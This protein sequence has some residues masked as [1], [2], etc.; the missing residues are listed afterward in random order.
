MRAHVVKGGKVVN[1]IEV[2][3]LDFMPGLI[4][5]TCGSIGWCCLDGALSP[6]AKELPD[7]KAKKIQLVEEIRYLKIYQ[8]SIPYTFP[9]D[10]DPDGIQMRDEVD[11]QNIQDL[12]I[13]AMLLDPTDTV[14]FMPV[15]NALKT[16]T[17][18]QM[19]Q[20]GQYL[21]TRGDQVVSRAW[22][23]KGQIRSA[24][25]SEDLENININ[26]GWPE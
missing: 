11:R 17:A 13:D 2:E 10:A 26:D 6:P 9:G 3:S 5:A 7:E 22:T 18:L 24:E 20:M 1:T 15:S 12:V 25:N 8:K 21:K 16:M 14:H 4:E 19:I 23:L